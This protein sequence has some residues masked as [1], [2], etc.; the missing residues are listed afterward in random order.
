MGLSLF[1]FSQAS[2]NYGVFRESTMWRNR[3]LH[4][5]NISLSFDHSYSQSVLSLIINHNWLIK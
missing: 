4:I 2:N 3:I 5:N 1:F